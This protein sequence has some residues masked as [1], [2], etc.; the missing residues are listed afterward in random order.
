MIKKLIK[1]A[2]HLDSI[3]KYD[4]ADQIDKVIF[5]AEWGPPKSSRKLYDDI[6]EQF[7]PGAPETELAGLIMG[8]FPEHDTR[9][10]KRLLAL[11][12]LLADGHSVE[13]V[14]AHENEF[15]KIDDMVF[16]WPEFEA[17]SKA[18]PDMWE[19]VKGAKQVFE[20][21]AKKVELLKKFKES[22]MP[23]Y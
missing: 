5:A 21:R 14:P 13:K 10:R 19:K 15:V 7:G 6:N 1:I 23:K 3:G 8:N 11:T 16:E 9:Q 20:D 18:P 22:K 2:E 4:L 12:K 17:M